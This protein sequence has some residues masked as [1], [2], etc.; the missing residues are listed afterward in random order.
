MRVLT[1][2]SA[3]NRSNMISCVFDDGYFLA[4]VSHVESIGRLFYLFVFV[5]VLDSLY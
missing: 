4:G 3:Q 5:I 1:N 2:N